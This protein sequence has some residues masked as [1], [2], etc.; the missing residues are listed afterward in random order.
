MSDIASEYAAVVAE[1]E[2]R[3]RHLSD[4]LGPH[5][6][7]GVTGAV[8]QHLERIDRLAAADMSWMDRLLADIH[9]ASP[10]VHALGGCGDVQE[11]ETVTAELDAV[12]C[13]LCLERP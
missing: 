2:A 12:T 5:Y 13:P 6:R 9:A 10:I 1:L 7:H 8:A 11:E 3:E 4:L